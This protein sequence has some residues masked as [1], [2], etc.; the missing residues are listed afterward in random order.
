MPWY[1]MRSDLG[2]VLSGPFHIKVPRNR[3][4]PACSICGYIGARQCDWRLPERGPGP[5]GGGATCDRW[6][7]PYCASPYPG[8][9]DLCPEHELGFRAWLATRT[10]TT[11]GPG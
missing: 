8:D 10:N 6:L 2:G 1:R 5:D 9:K 4:T 11:D 3:A 7:C